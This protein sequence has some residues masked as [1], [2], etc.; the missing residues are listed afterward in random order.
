MV[1]LS[2]VEVGVHYMGCVGFW[3]S[4]GGVSCCMGDGVLGA[5]CVAS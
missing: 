4:R 5:G 1:P 2:F 3:L